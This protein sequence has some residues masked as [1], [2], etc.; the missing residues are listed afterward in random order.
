MK[1]LKSVIKFFNFFYKSYYPFKTNEYHFA[2]I[3]HPRNINDA[4]RELSFFKYFPDKLLE[5]LINKL[6]P[7]IVSE[8]TGLKSLKTG[9][10]IKGCMISIN[11]LPQ[12]MLINRNLAIKKI[13]KAINIGKKRGVKIVGLGA[14]TS[15]VTTGGKDL[16]DKVKDVHITTGHAY[17]AYNIT[18]ILLNIV[19]EFNLPQDKLLIGIVGA[20][21]SIGST[22]TKL[23]AKEGFKNFILVDVERKLERINNLL[24]PELRGIIS[25]DGLNIKITSNIQEIKDCHFII[26]ATNSPETLIKPEYLSKGTIILDDAQPSDVDIS[27]LDR[28]D[29]IVIEAGLAHTPGIKTHFNFGFRDKYD[30]YSCLAEV[31]ILSA[32]EYKDHF[33]IHRATFEAI[34]KIKEWS[35]ELSFKPAEFQNFKELV[36]KD[37]LNKIISMMLE[38]IK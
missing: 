4:R 35:K 32:I 18:L 29:V 5:W 34:N 36:A 7:L 16:I 12:K 31:L 6:P 20:A 13:I 30:N 2:F 24:I 22:C 33:V 11:L 19:G 38:R 14:L 8:I 9:K 27:V 28:N 21:G 10:E 15:S 26:T 25:Q 17:T 3:V 1:F 37:K 23:L